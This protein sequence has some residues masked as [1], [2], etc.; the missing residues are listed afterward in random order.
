MYNILYVE[1]FVDMIWLGSN[2]A[3]IYY[4]YCWR[5]SEVRLQQTTLL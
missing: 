3:T 1:T 5:A 4:N 2:L